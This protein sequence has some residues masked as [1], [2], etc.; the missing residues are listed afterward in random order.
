MVTH[1]IDEALKLGDRVAVLRAGGVLA[2]LGTPHEL[3]TA[4]ADRFVADFVGAARGYRALGFAALGDSAEIDPEPGIRIGEA[5]GGSWRVVVDDDGRPLGW[6]D[7]TAH[8]AADEASLDGLAR[9]AT[10]DDSVRTLLEGAL[11]SPSG[12]VGVVDRANR[13]VGSLSAAQVIEAAREG[14]AA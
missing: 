6:V 1:D 12:R 7:G 9:F 2:Q 11:A 5:T 3:L 13:L 14:D 8:A 10:V 4:P